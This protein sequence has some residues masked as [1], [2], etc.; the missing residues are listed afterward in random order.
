MHAVLWRKNKPLDLG[1]LPDASVDQSLAADVNSSGQVVG[2]SQVGPENPQYGS[3]AH[4]AL[5]EVR[6]T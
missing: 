6:G 1:T 3:I 4:A 5:W 2:T